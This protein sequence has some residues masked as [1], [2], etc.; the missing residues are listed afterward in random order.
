MLM[1]DAPVGVLANNI[2]PDAP[3]GVL[4]N[5]IITQKTK[6][7]KILPA[8]PYP[9]IKLNYLLIDPVIFINQHCFLFLPVI[10]NSIA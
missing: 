1:L 10:E 5:S 3:V 6:P 2:I 9:N 4:A 8:L 7:V